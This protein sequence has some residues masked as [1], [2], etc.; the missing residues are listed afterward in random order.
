M[1]TAAAALLSVLLG[2]P[3]L[4]GC[5][6]SHRAEPSGV[7][8]V[9]FQEGVDAGRM[10]AGWSG[11]ERTEEGLTFVWAVGTSSSVRLG[12]ASR[13]PHTIELR[14]WA[15]DF[16]GAPPQDAVVFVN[17]CRVA[18][19]R[20]S[21]APADYAIATPWSVWTDGTNVLSFAFSRADAPR[22]RVAGATDERPLSVGFDRI[23]LRPG[24]V[25][26]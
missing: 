8:L 16:P 21:P 17:G 10:V 2:A 7:T 9:E 5:A 14:A 3:F 19:L 24:A 20:L 22:D 23:L 25:T 12:P 6:R 4:A 26:E 18:E 13:A 15:F 1:R 11:F